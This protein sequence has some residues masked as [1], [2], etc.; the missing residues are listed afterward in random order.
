MQRGRRPLAW[1]PVLLLAPALAVAGGLEQPGN[2]SAFVGRGGAF[3]AKADDL[4]AIIHNPAGLVKSRGRFTFHYDHA[5]TLFRESFNRSAT[6]PASGSPYDFAG[7]GIPNPVSNG[8]GWFPWGAMVVAA[9]DLGTRNFVLAAGV[10]GPPAQGRALFPADG[11]QKYA[12]VDRDVLILEYALAAAWRITPDLSI[13]ATLAWVDMP[14][15]RFSL[16][17]DGYNDSRY[18]PFKSDQDLL[19]R[20]DVADRVNVTATVGALWSPL[21]SLEVGL[22][23]RVL[24]VWIDARGTLA[25]T[26]L[27]SMVQPDSPG[28]NWALLSCPAGADTSKCRAGANG[29]R[30]RFVM[31]PDL[32]V[33]ARYVHRRGDI[34]VFDVELDLATEF[35]SMLDAFR[36]SLDADHVRVTLRDGSAPTRPIGSMVIPKRFKDTVSLRAG[37]DWAVVPGWLTLRAGAYWERGANRN[38]YTS[39]DF[40]ALDRV[41]VG[42]GFTLGW[43]GMALNAAYVHVFQLTQTMSEADAALLQQR[44]SELCSSDPGFCDPRY[45]GRVAPPVNA[46]TFRSGID[47]VTVGLTVG[48]EGW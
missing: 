41:G 36:V 47:V 38:A 27:G 19:A 14:R 24:P 15:G 4:T 48:T 31:P 33:G 40:L 23:S 16:V 10:Y 20:I 12:I 9:S 43:R 8:A 26:P 30:L 35:W 21:R 39:L 29:A 34:E 17:V 1:V 5:F 44:P 25:L 7:A 42:G 2:G 46:G 22:A 28:Q 11:S 6:D 3:V 18:R 45:P 37:G 13:G 32:R